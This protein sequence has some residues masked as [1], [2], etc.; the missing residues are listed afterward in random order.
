MSNRSTQLIYME[1]VL[2]QL[3]S[4]GGTGQASPKRHI[5]TDWP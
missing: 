3:Y 4:T 5:T 1:T 2:R